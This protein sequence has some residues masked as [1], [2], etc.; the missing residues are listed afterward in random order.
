MHLWFSLA[1]RCITP[2]TRPSFLCEPSH[3]L[4]ALCVSLPN[5]LFLKV[6]RLTLMNSLEFYLPYKTL[7]P[8]KS[9]FWDKG[10]RISTHILGGY[11]STCFN[12]CQQHYIYLAHIYV[13]MCVCVLSHFSHV[14]LCDPMGCSLQGSSVQGILQVRILECRAIPFSR[15]SSQPYMQKN[16]DILHA[17]LPPEVAEPKAN[18]SP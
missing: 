10:V 9:T 13:R 5:F 11:N 15:G 8:N 7:F 4:P 1:W 14:R 18:S 6:F 2:I 12:T 3:H 17:K 16:P